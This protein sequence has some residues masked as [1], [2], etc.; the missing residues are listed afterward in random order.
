[1][2]YCPQT[3]IFGQPRRPSDDFVDSSSGLSK[4]LLLFRGGSWRSVVARFFYYVFLFDGTFGWFVFR[5][6]PD[7]KG[8]GNRLG[9]SRACLVVAE[10]LRADLLLRRGLRV[11]SGLN[12]VPPA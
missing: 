9:V 12:P 11:A 7:L 3:S 6:D 2:K 4:L 1:M 5:D 8:W 10:V